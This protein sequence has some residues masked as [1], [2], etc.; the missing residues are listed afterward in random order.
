MIND[1]THYK[2]KPS[3][4]GNN[5]PMNKTNNKVFYNVDMKTPQCECIRGKSKGVFRLECLLSISHH[6]KILKLDA[7]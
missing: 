4:V 1:T 5:R 6:F 3:D 2:M 7:Y